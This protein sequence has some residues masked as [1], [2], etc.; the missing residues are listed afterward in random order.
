MIPQ[1]K[2]HDFINTLKKIATEYNTLYVYGSFG[3]H[4][5]SDNIERYL[6]RYAYNRQPHR[7]SLIEK[8][9]DKDV[10]G[11]DCV[12]LVKGVLW[13]WRGDPSVN[14]GGAVYESCSVPDVGANK[15]IELCHEVTEDFSNICI[16]ELLW[17]NDHCGVYVGDGLAVECTPLWNDGVQLTSVGNLE[18]APAAYHQRKWK[19]HGKLPFVEYQQDSH[20]DSDTESDMEIAP[21]PNASSDS[22]RNKISIFEILRR[23]LQLI[24][25]FFEKN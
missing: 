15:M 6:S 20:I 12:C 4:L 24:I 19:K 8:S 13:G 23:F 5:K 17:T 7:I 10:F 14:Y 2:A 25:S 21:P 3:E 18:N 22:S 16:G 9:L 11:F 1:M